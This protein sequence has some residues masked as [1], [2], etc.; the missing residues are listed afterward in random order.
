LSRLRRL[1]FHGAIHIV[2]VRGR[3]GLNIF[4]D[5]SV[6]SGTADRWRSSPHARRFLQLLDECCSEC[7]TE[8]FGYCIEPN[9]CS[10]LLRTQGASLDACMRRLG[11]RYSRYLHHEQV[12][13]TSI[14]PFGSR[15]EAKVVAPEYLP[16]ALR[17]LHAQPL[18]S[19]WARRAIDYPFS[20]AQAY[21]GERA[22]ARLDMNP[23]RMALQLKGLSGLRGYREF[24]ERAESA[25]V[26]ALFEKGSSIDARVIG[27]DT[28][29]QQARAMAGH[30][31]APV[32]REQLIAGVAALL[33]VRKEELFESGHQ[34]VRGRALVA[35][36]AL[37]FGVGSLREVGSWFEVSGTAL[38]KSIR[39]YRRVSPELFAKR[40][41]PGIEIGDEEMGI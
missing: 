14:C 23:L 26:M 35:S 20:S 12:V 18:D 15:Y 37:R 32:S 39:Y 41:L 31:P 30:P 5:A 24:M 4:F 22:R 33:G 7:G 2:H 28:F 29:V 13:P 11:G 27:G 6:L 9:E 21:L 8:M 40:T 34:A 19:G 17:R 1:D 10:L 25:H 38:G 36:Y 3:K 16:H